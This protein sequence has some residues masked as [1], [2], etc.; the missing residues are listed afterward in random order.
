MSEPKFK[1]G[2][3][4]W[5]DLTSNKADNLKEFYKSVAGWQ[6]FPVAMRDEEGEYNDYAMLV[7][8]ENAAGGICNKRGKNNSL[9]TQWIMYIYAEDVEERLK[10]A[11]ELGGKLIHESRKPDG[12]YNYVII[13][14]PVGAVFG[15]GNMQ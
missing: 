9:P 7:D 6:E 5:A 8:P 10:T 2:Q 11:Q 14:D 1:P 3:I 4:V 15:I 13:E 12:T